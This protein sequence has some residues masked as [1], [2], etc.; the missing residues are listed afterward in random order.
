MNEKKPPF[1]RSKQHKTDAEKETLEVKTFEL[2]S[3]LRKKGF[4]GNISLPMYDQI[5]GKLKVEGFIDPMDAGKIFNLGES[6]E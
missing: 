6:G 2:I 4:Q 5:I 1:D 3:R